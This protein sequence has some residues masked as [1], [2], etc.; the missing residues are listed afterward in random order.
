MKRILVIAFA[1]ALMSASAIAQ[2]A[3]QN[4]KPAAQS[5]TQSALTKSSAKETEMK[6]CKDHDKKSSSSCEHG[7]TA[8]GKSSCCMHSKTEAKAESKETNPE[9]K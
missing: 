9:K 5:E 3:Q 8:A 2:T 6:E 7:K 4:N 1:S